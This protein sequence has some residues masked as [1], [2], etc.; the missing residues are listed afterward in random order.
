MTL[1]KTSA[2]IE[3]MRVGGKILATVLQQV[4]AAAQPGITT[5]ELNRLAEQGL[6]ERGATPSFLGYGHESDD[7][8][9]ATLCTSVDAAVV[10]AIP[11][12]NQELREGQIVGLDLGCWYQGLCT[13]MAVTVPVGRVSREAAK[14][15]KVTQAAL[16]EGLQ[17]LRAGAR[18]GD[19]GHAIQTY[20]E[21]NGFSVVRQLTGHGV[22]RAVHEEPGIPN[23][24]RPG[25]GAKLDAGMTIAVEPMVNIGGAAVETL[26][27]GWTVVSA[28]SSLSAHVELTVLVTNQGYEVLTTL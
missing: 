3:K 14:L 6:R 28:D 19:I 10:H 26:A 7:P 8:Y 25:T 12:P 24:G 11:S 27:D 9:P 13:D 21:A 4:A 1:V 2:E 15:I 23:F 16:H 5:G 17:H 20:V 22:G 18:V